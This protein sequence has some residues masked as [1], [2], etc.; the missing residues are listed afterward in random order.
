MRVELRGLDYIS[1][2]A[3]KGEFGDAGL[4]E[5]TFAHGDEL[6]I[7]IEGGLCEG[8]LDV[9]GLGQFEGDAGVLRRVFD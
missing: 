7:L 9:V 5:F 6:G 4:V 1:A 8:G 3:F 2:A